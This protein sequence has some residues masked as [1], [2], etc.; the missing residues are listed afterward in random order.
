G[1]TSA[2]A[3]N[4]EESFN[5]QLVEALREEIEDL[6]AQTS[7]TVTV[8]TSEASDSAAAEGD[9]GQNIVTAE[10]SAMSVSFEEVT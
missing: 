9:E 3:E 5:N 6:G 4:T 8:K 10:T 7:T 1:S 2:E